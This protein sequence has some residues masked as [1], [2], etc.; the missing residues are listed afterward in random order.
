MVFVSFFLVVAPFIEEIL[1]E[2]LY[3][4]AVIIFLLLYYPFVHKRYRVPGIGKHTTFC[5][6]TEGEKKFRVNFYKMDV[7]D[8]HK[9]AYSS[10]TMISGDIN[11]EHL[12]S[13]AVSKIHTQSFTYGSTKI[14]VTKN[15]KIFLTDLEAIS[16]LTYFYRSSGAM[17]P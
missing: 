6:P 16:S 14:S 7:S 1:E 15:Y 12:V 5:S 10:G 13:F 9:S 2:Y 17:V 4:I 8:E 11:C 3:G